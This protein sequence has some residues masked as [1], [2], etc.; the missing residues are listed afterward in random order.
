MAPLP[1]EVE[2]GAAGVVNGEHTVLALKDRQL[3]LVRL[4][5]GERPQ[6]QVHVRCLPLTDGRVV[7]SVVDNPQEMG[8]SDPP[9]Y[10]RRWE[11]AWLGGPTV[12]L[13][14]EVHR[15]RPFRGDGPDTVE[16]LARMV[17]RKLGWDVPA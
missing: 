8:D 13:L 10:F 15:P 11:F 9:G 5:A 17:A 4:D 12:R 7:I 1:D 6:A 14:G 2:T 16:L 3:F